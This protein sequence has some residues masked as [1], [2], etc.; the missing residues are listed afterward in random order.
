MKALQSSILVLPSPVLASAARVLPLTHASSTPRPRHPIL[1]TSYYAFHVLRLSLPVST[2]RSDLSVLA[3]QRTSSTSDQSFSTPL[4]DS[5][6]PYKTNT[7]NE[8]HTLLRLSLSFQPTDPPVH[9]LRRPF[10]TCSPWSDQ[11][12]T[13]TCLLDDISSVP[14]TSSQ[15]G[16]IINHLFLSSSKLATPKSALDHRFVGS[17][18]VSPFV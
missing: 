8:H 15:I 16:S 11:P 17:T 3:F 14:F 7:A 10:V 18:V 13:A 1:S 6:Y 12:Q 4:V 2:S 5:G 9:I